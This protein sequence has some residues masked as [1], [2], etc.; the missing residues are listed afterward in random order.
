MR[1]QQFEIEER[2]IEPLLVVGLRMKGKYSDCGQGFSKL[3]KQVG[4]YIGGKALCLYY[5][6]EYREDDADFE[7][8]FPLRKEVTSEE[9]HVRTLSGVHC[10]VLMHRGPYENLRE[11]YDRLREYVKE[12]RYEVDLPSREVYVK[13]PGMIFKGNPKKYLTEIQLPIKK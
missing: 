8:C 10:A 13:G 3:A 1:Q 9:F 5:D 7:P 12:K 11:S 4:R 2:F 6:G